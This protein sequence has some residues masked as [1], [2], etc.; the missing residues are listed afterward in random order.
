MTAAAWVA[1]AETLNIAPGMVVAFSGRFSLVVNGTLLANGTNEDSIRVQR[2]PSHAPEGHLG[3]RF[4]NAA[5]VSRL[6]HVL[7]EDG[8]ANVGNE[9]RYGG[10]VE[11]YQAEVEIDSCS[12]RGNRARIDG[13]AICAVTQPR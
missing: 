8:F 7:F 4:R 3:F 1:Q 13:G 10:A 11:L 5:T 2:T 12:F 6:N 9:E